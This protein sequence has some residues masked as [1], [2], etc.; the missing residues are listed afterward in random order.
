MQSQASRV[1]H[2]EYTKVFGIGSVLSLLNRMGI[3]MV[4]IIIISLSLC[5]T[6]SGTTNRGALD[7]NITITT[8]TVIG[9]VY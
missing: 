4:I 1:L 8:T 9:K 2:R 7:Y 5:L 3:I 6:Y